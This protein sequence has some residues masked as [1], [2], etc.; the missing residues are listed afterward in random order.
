[1][2]DKLSIFLIVLGFIFVLFLG[3]A[4]GVFVNENS[5]VK[6]LETASYSQVEIVDRAIFFI[7][8]RGGEDTDAARFK[9][10]AINPAGKEVE[11]YIF[12]G[13]PFKGATVRGL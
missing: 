8:L 6:A 7:G 11:V 9:A 3:F 13:W 5:A 4:R 1:M 2:K 12:V 10:K